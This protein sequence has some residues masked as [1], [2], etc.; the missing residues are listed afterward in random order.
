MNFKGFSLEKKV[1]F[2]SYSVDM[3]VCYC[4]SDLLYTSE[5]FTTDDPPSHETLEKEGN[6]LEVLGKGRIVENL[7][8]H[9]RSCKQNR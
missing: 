3:S 1:S 4:S 2:A 9:V 5:D 8:S 7:R 6:H